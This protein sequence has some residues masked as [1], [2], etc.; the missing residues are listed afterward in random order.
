MKIS[1][2]IENNTNL[3]HRQRYTKIKGKET[4]PMAN[5]KWICH[6]SQCQLRHNDN[7][8]LPSHQKKTTQRIK[9]GTEKARHKIHE[10]ELHVTVTS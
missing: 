7:S 6:L 4:R 3:A 9:M 2:E 5:E 8:T 10:E 1:V